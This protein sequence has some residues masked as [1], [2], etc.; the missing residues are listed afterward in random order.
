MAL[1]SIFMSDEKLI[2]TSSRI[3]YLGILK[4]AASE[5][6]WHAVTLPQQAIVKHVGLLCPQ[7]IVGQDQLIT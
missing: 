5:D 1:F 7:A 2:Q 4:L 6:F 3:I